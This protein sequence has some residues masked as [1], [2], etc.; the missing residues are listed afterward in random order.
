[1]FKM[2]SITS[3][4][5]T[6]CQLGECMHLVSQ[7]CTTCTL[8]HIT[9]HCIVNSSSLVVFRLAKL[10]NL[11]MG[12]RVEAALPLAGARSGQERRLTD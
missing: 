5:A 12:A 4:L 8:L 1:M 7:A 6:W 9:T 11:T 10:T 3:Q 2:Y